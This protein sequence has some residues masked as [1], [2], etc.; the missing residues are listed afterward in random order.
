MLKLGMMFL[1]Y[2]LKSFPRIHITCM[3]ISIYTIIW[4]DLARLRTGVLLSL[5]ICADIPT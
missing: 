2:E 1:I 5:N 3:S 4:I